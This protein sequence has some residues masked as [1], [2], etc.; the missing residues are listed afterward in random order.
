[1][2]DR[3]SLARRARQRKANSSFAESLA[4]STRCRTLIAASVSHATR[5]GAWAPSPLAEEGWGRGVAAGVILQGFFPRDS[6][7]GPPSPTL[8]RKG[9]G[10]GSSCI[11]TTAPN[12]PPRCMR[13]HRLRHETHFRIVLPNASRRTSPKA[14][15]DTARAPSPLAGEGGVRGSRGIDS[16]GDPTPSARTSLVSTQPG[17][18]EPTASS[19]HAA[20]PPG[21]RIPLL[22]ASRSPRASGSPSGTVP[23][24]GFQPA[25][26]R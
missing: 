12:Q 15:R 4:D 3:R 17:G 23:G 24:C 20:A 25:A 10:S 1:M 26:R 11:K 9:E 2:G 18:Q 14:T 22:P 6:S 7:R 8:P 5:R 16:C 21:S 13:W 19:P